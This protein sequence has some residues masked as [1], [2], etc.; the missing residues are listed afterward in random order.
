[1]II[2]NPKY[3]LCGD[4]TYLWSVAELRDWEM[5]LLSLDQRDPGVIDCLKEVRAILAEKD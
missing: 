4:P 2:R 5:E 3:L 1:M